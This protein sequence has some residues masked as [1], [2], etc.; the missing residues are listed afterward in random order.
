MA[1]DNRRKA[2]VTGLEILR[3]LAAAVAGYLGGS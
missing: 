2:I 3:L 1:Y